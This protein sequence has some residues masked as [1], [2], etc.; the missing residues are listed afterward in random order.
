MKTL[1][2]SVP[3]SRDPSPFGDACWDMRIVAGS[4]RLGFTSND[5]S[6]LFPMVVYTECGS[7]RLPCL[8]GFLAVGTWTAMLPQR[9]QYESNVVGARGAR[10]EILLR[11]WALHSALAA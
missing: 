6:T 1:V 3:C 11:S 4:I 8:F 5:L 7:Y 9:A 10:P 2:F